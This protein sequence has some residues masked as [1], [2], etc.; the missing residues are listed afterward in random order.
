M[1]AISGKNLLLVATAIV[2]ATSFTYAQRL[3]ND[4]S[5]SLRDF[6]D[7]SELS[8]RSFE[9]LSIREYINDQIDL[10]LR[11]YDDIL[12]ELIARQAGRPS[13]PGPR[14][15]PRPAPRPPP[16]GVQRG[17]RRK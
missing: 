13:R 9:P 4:G 3:Y 1:V 14:P 16:T 10:A 8:S 2:G 6:E 12:D 17:P 7:Y 5:L 15:E 11:D